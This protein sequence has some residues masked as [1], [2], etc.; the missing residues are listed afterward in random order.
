MTQLPRALLLL[1]AAL[2]DA[3]LTRAQLPFYTDDSAVTEKGKLHF[4]F[5]NEYDALLRLSP[6]GRTHGKCG[7]GPLHLAGSGLP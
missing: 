4:E 5:F 2:L 6:F 7:A 1:F 3:G